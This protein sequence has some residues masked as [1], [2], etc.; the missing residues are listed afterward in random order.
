[1]ARQGRNLKATPWMSMRTTLITMREEEKAWKCI[2]SWQG[3]VH[4]KYSK[5]QV[6]LAQVVA[7][8]CT[9]FKLYR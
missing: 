8:L 3:H 2:P 1:M 5:D 6:H 9:Y 4:V 7:R